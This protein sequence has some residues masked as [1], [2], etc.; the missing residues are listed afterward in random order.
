[1]GRRR[2]PVADLKPGDSET[3]PSR[4]FVRRLSG[5]SVAAIADEVRLS[6]LPVRG[7]QESAR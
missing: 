6:Y 3:G 7:A 4:G 1:M 2:H 5:R